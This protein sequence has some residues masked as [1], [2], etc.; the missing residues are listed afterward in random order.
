MK[1]L[2]FNL[3]QLF[4][5][6]IAIALF[7]GWFKMVV[8]PHTT[9]EELTTIP[10][11]I[12]TSFVIDT[13]LSYKYTKDLTDFQAT[14]YHIGGIVKFLWSFLC[15]LFKWLFPFFLVYWTYCFFKKAKQ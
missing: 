9:L 11:V 2:R 10:G 13:N 15:Y 14:F 3:K 7:L 12:Y 4:I 6:T 1:N 5:L 8:L